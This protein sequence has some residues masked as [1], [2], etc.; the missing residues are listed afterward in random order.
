MLYVPCLFGYLIKQMQFPS[1]Q[2]ASFPETAH[3]TV[4]PA[5]LLPGQQSKYFYTTPDAT[6]NYSSQSLFDH[7]SGAAST[8]EFAYGEPNRLGTQSGYLNVPHTVSRHLVPLVLPSAKEAAYGNEPFQLPFP[9]LM[10]GDIAFYLRL[11]SGNWDSHHMP[12]GLVCRDWDG[13]MQL[14]RKR[15]VPSGE[16]QGSLMMNEGANVSFLFISLHK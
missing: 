2:D 8:N 1:V 12:L 13:A 6:I 16:M 10:K 5:P 11:E 7:L 4:N 9:H 14:R 15:R 3:R